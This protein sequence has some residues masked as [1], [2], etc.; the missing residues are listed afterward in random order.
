MVYNPV[1]SV[2]E[3]RHALLR[4]A[5]A[6]ISNFARFLKIVSSF[7]LAYSQRFI[8]M[9]FSLY[10]CAQKRPKLKSHSFKSCPALKHRWFNAP[11][12]MSRLTIICCP[13]PIPDS[14]S[15]FCLRVAVQPH[16][17]LSSCL[18]P[19]DSWIS[20]ICAMSIVPPSSLANSDNPDKLT[21]V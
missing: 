6:R 18:L 3:R 1:V 15:V 19:A 16:L 4:I 13:L 9:Q 5:R 10:T 2:T 21:R 7:C 14:S 17:H 20:R 8:M 12:F 11:S